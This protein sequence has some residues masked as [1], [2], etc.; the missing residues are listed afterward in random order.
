MSYEASTIGAEAD[1][2][3]TRLE[4]DLMDVPG[5]TKRFYGNERLASGNSMSLPAWHAE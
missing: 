5:G 4:L 1:E 3:K 2:G